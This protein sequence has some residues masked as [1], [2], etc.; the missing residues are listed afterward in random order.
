MEHLIKQYSLVLGEWIHLKRIFPNSLSCFHQLSNLTLYCFNP[1]YP[2][3]L[4]T[5]RINH[6]VGFFL[7]PNPLLNDQQ[8]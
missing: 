7:C 2:D 4:K 6:S 3:N 8:K 1:D 5:N